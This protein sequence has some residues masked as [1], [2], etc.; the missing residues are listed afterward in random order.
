[1]FVLVEVTHEVDEAAGDVFAHAVD[2]VDAFGGDLDHDF[3]AVFAGVEAFDVAEFFE[4][5]DEA[6]GG[7]GAVAHL[8]GD[9]GHGE[10]LLIGEVAEE[11]ELGEGDAAF[12]EFFGEVQ[13]EGALGE[14][15]EIRQSSG[16]LADEGVFV[17]NG[18]HGWE[19]V[20]GELCGVLETRLIMENIL[21][22]KP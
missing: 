15:D 1:L 6:G 17:F 2:E 13:Q 19:G 20:G 16:I 5:V 10:E 3:A 4:A 18:L 11:E 22:R 12:V 21:L 8:F 7:G 14:H 9:V